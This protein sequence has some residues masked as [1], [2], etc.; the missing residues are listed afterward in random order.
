MPCRTAG[1]ATAFWLGL[2]GIFAKLA[3]VIT[4]IPQPVLG[5]MTTFLFANVGCVG[6]K[7][8][9]ACWHCAAAEV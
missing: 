8:G 3:A 7:V 2:M 5:G 9:P 4:T 1:Y 6:I